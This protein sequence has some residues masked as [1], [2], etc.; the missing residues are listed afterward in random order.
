MIAETKNI[1]R[2]S[3]RKKFLAFLPLFCLFVIIF[4]AFADFS[5]VYA[6]DA[7]MKNAKEIGVK[8]RIEI[9]FSQPI[10][11][12]S[13]NNIKISPDVDFS[14]NLLDNRKRLIIIPKSS[15]SFEQKYTVTLSG[16]RGIGGLSIDGR[17]FV[18]YTQSDPSANTVTKVSSAGSDQFGEM[19]LAKDKYIPPEKSRVKEDFHPEAHI[20]TG[21]YIDISLAHQVMTLF[22]DGAEVN[23]FLVSTGK[24]GMPTPQGEFSV[25]TKE[26][27]HWSH[28][29]K[30][31]MPY[32]MEFN[33]PDFIHEL[34]YWPNGY[35][36][37]ENH[38][39]V[40]VSHG[41]VRLGIGPAKYVFDWAEI[42][43]PV[44]VHK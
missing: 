44:Y 16:I 14:Y 33:G 5:G 30:L 1:I 36:E 43:T 11:L 7:E 2:G 15:L 27:N 9:D 20:L 4:A 23:Q 37:G 8:D 34:P 22:E 40:K 6:F 32:S 24:F 39:G 18:F 29:Y 12:I 3:R 10:F 21:K 28:Q 41:C 17:D 38:L 26:L 19:V 25:K 13:A 42:G 35:R 31:W